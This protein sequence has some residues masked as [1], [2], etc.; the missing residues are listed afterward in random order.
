MVET[1][2]LRD[3]APESPADTRP[4]L[5]Q[6]GLFEDLD[7]LDEL[8][9]ALCDLGLHVRA[10]SLPGHGGS[11]CD[12]GDLVFYNLEDYVNPLGRLLSR[13]KP[14]PVV[15]THGAASL[16]MLRLLEDRKE[17]AHLV[18]ELPGWVALQPA[19]P[20]G[21]AAFRK[22]LFSK[23]P[24]AARKVAF[25]KRPADWFRSGRAKAWLTTPQDPR[26]AS[27]VEAL[28][29][30]ESWQ[31]VDPLTR[32]IDLRPRAFTPKTLVLAGRQDRLTEASET[33]ALAADLNAE[34]EWLED[35]GAW[36]RPGDDTRA[37]AERIAAFV[38]KTG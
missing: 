9:R 3:Y 7:Q 32:G 11:T 35:T 28:V 37:V 4:V 16:M 1:I 6:H 14:L 12:K 5:L 17:R 25:A 36:L 30:D 15:V 2:E 27:A 21:L 33:E 38:R 29:R 20:E 22:R 24:I 13:A 26:D 10:H 18:Q 34:L 19:A 23:H 8:A 31:V